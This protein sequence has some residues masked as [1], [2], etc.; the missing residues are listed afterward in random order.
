MG[1]LAADTPPLEIKQEYRVVPIDSL[2]PHPKNPNKGDVGVI[3]ESIEANG[4]YGAVV[5]QEIGGRRK[6]LRILVGE[7]RWRAARRKGATEIPVIVKDVDDATAM[8]IMLVDNESARQAT[9]DEDM[10]AELLRSLDTLDGTGFDLGF[11]EE[12]EARREQEEDTDPEPGEG[13][14][15]DLLEPGEDK[16]EAQY[17]V[18]VVCDDEKSQQSTFE[19]LK[20]QGFRCRVVSV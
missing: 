12:I 3:E 15:D 6:K 20:G 2:E 1:R 16:Y 8:R 11:L 7:H 19:A 5:V 17:G 14:E 4:F 9:Y 18:I 10:L 13:S